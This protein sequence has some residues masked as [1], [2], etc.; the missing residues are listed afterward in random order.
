LTRKRRTRQHV[1][2]DLSYNHVEKFVL[3][4]HWSA[5]PQRRDYGIDMTIHTYSDTGEIENGWV[6]VQLK[7]TDHI[8]FSQSG[9]EV[10]FHLDRSDLEY[11]LY[12]PYPVILVRYD[13]RGEVGYWLDVKSYFSARSGFDLAKIG[14]TVSVRIPAKNVVNQSAIREFGRLKDRVVRQFWG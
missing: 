12:E 3:Y 7:A 14:K 5:E 10:L 2:E 6:F 1:I 13:A 4:C 8:A 11:W 9:T